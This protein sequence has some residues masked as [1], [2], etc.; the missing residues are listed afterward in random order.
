MLRPRSAD[1]SALRAGDERSRRRP[2]YTWT[3]ELEHV[4]TGPDTRAARRT[5]AWFRKAATPW[6]SD[7]RGAPRWPVSSRRSPT[8]GA[9]A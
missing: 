8:T 6:R 2:A 7:P 4:A 5:I 3:R 9:F 1:E